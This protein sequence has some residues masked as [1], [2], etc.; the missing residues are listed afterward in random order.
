MN[1]EDAKTML[2]LSMLL[3]V[4]KVIEM[5]EEQGS[6]EFCSNETLP[7]KMGEGDK[8][9][10]EA[11]G[12]QFLGE[13]PGDS[14]FQYVVL[15]NGWK[16]ESESSYWTNL[17]DDK[18]RTRALIFY[19]AAFYDR[20]SHLNVVSKFRLKECYPKGC[21][22]WNEGY[23]EVTFGDEVIFTTNIKDCEEARKDA[24]DWLD[25]N[26]PD[27]RDKSNYWD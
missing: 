7:I 12:I 25:T 15:P 27:W 2:G 24:K 10:L 14:L 18:G 26:Y 20:R 9:V 23:Y 3:G 17:L 19:K 4:D 11:W 8:E 6:K 1:S 21:T 22:N 13:V 5:Q 16:K